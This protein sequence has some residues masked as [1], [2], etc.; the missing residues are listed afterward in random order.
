MFL[1]P[2]H[3]LSG[4]AGCGSPETWLRVRFG[5]IL[6]WGGL[7]TNIKLENADCVTRSK[8]LSCA[9]QGTQQLASGSILRAVPEGPAGPC[10]CP[11][12]STYCHTGHTIQ[13]NHPCQAVLFQLPSLGHAQPGN[14]DRPDQVPVCGASDGVESEG[15]HHLHEGHHPW[16]GVCRGEGPGADSAGAG[17]GCV[18]GLKA[19]QYTLHQTPPLMLYGQVDPSATRVAVLA[20]GIT[21]TLGKQRN[22][23]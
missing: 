21:I 9:A 10:T 6:K 11:P 23:F 12:P 4:V 1:N 17:G 2:Y 18:S 8:L 16:A 3:N 13:P 20:R 14:C 5:D 7:R 15:D 22:L 19:L